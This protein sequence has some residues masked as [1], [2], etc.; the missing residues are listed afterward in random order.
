MDEFMRNYIRLMII[1]LGL[2]V[3]G[4]CAESQNTTMNSTDQT[5]TTQELTQK[6]EENVQQPV[7]STNLEESSQDNID[8]EVTEMRLI[9]VGDN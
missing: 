2:V 7:Q 9:A 4:G 1:I 6:K 3:L 5:E 8:T